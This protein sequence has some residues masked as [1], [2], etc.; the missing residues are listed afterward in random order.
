VG[1]GLPLRLREPRAPLTRADPYAC[2]AAVCAGT[3]ARPV[4]VRPAGVVHRTGAP[5][6]L[7][8][9]VCA[10]T[11]SLA[12]SSRTAT[13]W[14]RP[15]RSSSKPRSAA[16]AAVPPVVAPPSTP[17]VHATS[18]SHASTGSLVRRSGLRRHRL[19]RS[20]APRPDLIAMGRG[21]LRTA[22]LLRGAVRPRRQSG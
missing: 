6:L 14:R 7:L 11:V 15:E 22:A 8:T 17:T 4:R 20:V 1:R 9:S 3:A 5:A 16:S 19:A 12:F 2:P 10:G 21:P 13:T 18:S